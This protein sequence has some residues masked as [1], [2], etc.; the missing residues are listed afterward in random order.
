M[1]LLILGPKSLGKVFDL[2]LEPLIEELLD[3]WTGVN[4]LDACTGWK[5]NL[6]A[7][8]LWCIHDYP[9][10]STL[11][12]QTA[13]GYYACIH[14]DKNP[15]SRAIRNKICYLGHRRYLPTSHASRR[16]LAFDGHRENEVEPGKFTTEE[17]LEE[18]EKVKY[19]RP[20][21]HT[22]TKKRK[23]DEGPV[24]YSRKAGLWRLPYWQHL[25][26]PYNLDVMHIKKNICDNLLGTL[27]KIE[28]KTK[29]TVNARLDLLD[30]GIRP[31]LH[32]N[33]MQLNHYSSCFLCLGEGSEKTVLQVSQRHQVS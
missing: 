13:K 21:K 27:L 18:L 10:L 19:V 7:A 3:L 31:E 8:V 15:L 28:G 25:L 20:R 24:I 26:L 23:R 14:Y 9:A 22:G 1:D 29:D 17:V 4:T 11:S 6:R 30:M 2:F 12:G 16:S 5:F 32:L 33:R